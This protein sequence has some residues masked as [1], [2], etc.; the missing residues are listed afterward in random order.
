MNSPTPTSTEVQK[1]RKLTSAAAVSHVAAP[2]QGQRHTNA[3]S[4]SMLLLL[5]VLPFRLSLFQ[6][7]RG[8]GRRTN[9]PSLRC[10]AHFHR[11][12]HV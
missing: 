2:L 10:S 8:A 4:L 6:Q 3:S 5:R 7:G 9:A 12:E 1:H 11:R